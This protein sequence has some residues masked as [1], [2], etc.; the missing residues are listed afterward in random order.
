[1]SKQNLSNLF[2]TQPDASKLSFGEV[3]L[4]RGGCLR[5]DFHDLLSRVE[6]SDVTV[7]VISIPSLDVTPGGGTVGS[8]RRCYHG[9]IWNHQ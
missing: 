8:N 3:V 6:L 2:V 4:E 1:V 5:A 9:G 7:Q